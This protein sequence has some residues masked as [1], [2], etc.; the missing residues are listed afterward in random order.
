MRE[1]HYCKVYIP[2]DTLHKRIHAQ[3]PTVPVPKTVNALAA[4]TQLRLLE[5]AGAISDDDN[6][7]KRLMVLA[8]L[9]DCVEQ[10]TADAFREQQRIAHEFYTKKP[11]D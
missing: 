11:S 3:V 4:L 9:F 7:E 6:I 2:K 5:Q 1:F 8:A 10:P